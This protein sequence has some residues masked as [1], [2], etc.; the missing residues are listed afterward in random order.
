MTT[1][2]LVSDKQL[3]IIGG[4]AVVGTVLL[5]WGVSRFGG[6]VVDTAGGILSGNNSLTDGTAY[7]GAGVVGTVGAATNTISGGFLGELGS[8][9][10]LALFDLF[11]PS[12]DPNGDTL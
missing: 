6:A 10:S 5:I 2:T 1:A 12:Y 4:V 8:D 9:L 11:G 7:E 3:L